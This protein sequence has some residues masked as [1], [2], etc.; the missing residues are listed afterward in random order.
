MG[1]DGKSIL[2]VLS[3]VHDI[4]HVLYLRLCMIDDRGIAIAITDEQYDYITAYF[5]AIQDELVTLRVKL[6]A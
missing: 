6:R 3:S 1:K 2:N 5:D 4:F